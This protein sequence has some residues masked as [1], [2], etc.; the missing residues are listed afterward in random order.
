MNLETLVFFKVKVTVKFIRRGTGGRKEQ[1]KYFLFP[2]QEMVAK[3][4][5]TYF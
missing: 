4:Q 1:E 2:T 3:T 5:E